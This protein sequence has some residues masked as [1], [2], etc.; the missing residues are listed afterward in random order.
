VKTLT[1]A[2]AKAFYDRFGRR[3]DGQTFYEAPALDALVSHAELHDAGSLFE[4]GCGT[5]RFAFDLLSER[6]PSNARYV[7][8]DIS[9]TMVRLASERLAAFGPRA[10]VATVA[11][12][13]PLTPPD[14]S[15]DRFVSTYVLDLLP[16]P[17]ARQVVL[18]ARR[19]LRPGGLLCL[20]G[21]TFGTTPLSK[22]VMAGWRRLFAWNPSWVGGCRP[23][24]LTESV[25]EA[26]WI[27]R[28][29]TVVV[30]WGVASEVL[31]ASPR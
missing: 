30:A 21:V 4:F 12:G 11:G 13:F 8:V 20:A 10:T 2:E 28:F 22:V 23:T 18:E 6:L 26:D 3:Q 14:S 31:V 1:T 19:L 17:A 29:H 7:G 27:T 24:K 25:S 5:G 15:V 9:T 16:A